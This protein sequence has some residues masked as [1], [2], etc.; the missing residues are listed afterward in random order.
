MK[1]KD[2]MCIF[3]CYDKTQKKYFESKGLKSLIYG[4][5]PKTMKTFWVFERT[6]YFNK[7]FEE[8]LSRK[9]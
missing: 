3:V 2:N 5:H 9:R 4:L 7:V 1:G 6:D 8:W